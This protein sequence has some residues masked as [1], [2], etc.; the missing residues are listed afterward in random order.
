MKNYTLI[1][2]VALLIG[3][4]TSTSDSVVL[5][6]MQPGDVGEVIGFVEEADSSFLVKVI[7]PGMMITFDTAEMSSDGTQ[8]VYWFKP[9]GEEYGRGLAT[10]QAAQVLVK[11]KEKE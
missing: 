7:E 6:D 3:G 1:L 4:C 2:F 11:P 8:M 9:D 10:Y 5:K